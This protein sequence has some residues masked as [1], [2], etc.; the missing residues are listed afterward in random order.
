[1]NAKTRPSP[2]KRVKS[3]AAACTILHCHWSFGTD[4][5]FRLHLFETLSKLDG[6]RHTQIEMVFCSDALR[7]RQN[8]GS[9]APVDEAALDGAIGSRLNLR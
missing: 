8:I 7:E 9:Q 6:S 5:T 3:D 4:S 1:M 2:N